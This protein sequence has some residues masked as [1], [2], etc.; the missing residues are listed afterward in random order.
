MLSPRDR[1]TSALAFQGTDIVPYHIS[2]DPAIAAKLERALGAAVPFSTFTNHLPFINVEAKQFWTS[3]DR[4]TDE[5]GSAWKVLNQVPHL[6]QHPLIKPSLAGYS[7]PKFSINEYAEGFRQFLSSHTNQFVLCGI[8]QGF[9]DRGWALRGIENFLVDFIE[10]PL[11][12][13]QLFEALTDYY[14]QMLDEIASFP[15]DGIRFGDDWGAQRGLLMGPKHWRKF[16]KPGLMKIFDK[17]RRLGL[18]VMVHSDGDIM[19]IIPDLI[20]IGVQILNPIQPEAMN[21]YEIKRLYGNALCLNGGISSQFTLPL[22]TAEDVRREVAACLRYMA[23]GGGYVVGPAKHILPDTPFENIVAL[24][25]TILDQPVQPLP[26]AEKLRD[27]VPE[28]ERV[29][30][31]FQ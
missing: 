27:S 19:E 1:V 17:A 22:G 12:V 9:Y 10:S 5:F 8:A 4:Y 14:L 26:A 6:V 13:E 21:I 28:L 24:F 16:I 23:H 29:Y 30:S 11:F 20:E 3:A 18:T 31:T 25:E 7:L 15:F 2:F